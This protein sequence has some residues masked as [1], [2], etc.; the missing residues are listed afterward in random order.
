MFFKKY[1]EEKKAAEQARSETLVRIQNKLD[2]ARVCPDAGEKYLLLKETDIMIAQALIGEADVIQK[3]ADG[4]A[5]NLFMAGTTGGTA[6]VIGSIAL[7]APLA[8]L[9]GIVAL[10]AAMMW[11]A[12]SQRKEIKRLAKENA[13]VEPL[14][15]YHV[16]VAALEAEMLERQILKIAASPKFDEVCGKY[17]EVS[18]HFAR[19]AVMKKAI[20]NIRRSK[21]GP[22]SPSF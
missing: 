12:K 2:E 21:D 16:D 4:R 6:I 1:R 18:Q 7:G 5:S 11:A 8:G 10:P 22:A 17:P 14:L 19:S 20:E 15:K 9:A 3:K 13:F